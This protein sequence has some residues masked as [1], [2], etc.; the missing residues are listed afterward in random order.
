MTTQPDRVFVGAAW[1]YANGSLHAGHLA[2]AY[3]PAD[4][5]A[6][7]ARMTGAEVLFV[8]GSDCHGAPIT[9]R[10]DETGGSP[11]AV[12]SKYHQEFLHNWEQL[13]ISFDL[14]TTTMTSTHI[15]VVQDEFEKLR[16]RGLLVERETTA[17][18]DEQAERFLP[19]R[20]VIGECSHCGFDG[21]RGDQ[22]TSCGRPL[23]ADDILNARS[24]TTGTPVV[25]RPTRHFFLD[26]PQLEDQLQEWVNAS[27]G[28]WRRHVLGE[29]LG[30]LEEG[31]RPRAITRNLDWGVRVPVD[32]WD[33]RRIYVWF[34]AVTG[35]LSASMEWA[36]SQDDEDA[37]RHWWEDEDARQYYFLG[38]DNIPFH[39]L[40]WPAILIGRGDLAQLPY[41]VPANCFLNFAGEKASKSEGVGFS[42]N[43]LLARYDADAVRFYLATAM[44]ENDDS[45]FDLNDL[46]ARVNSELIG[47]WGNLVNRTVALVV[48]RLSGEVPSVDIDTE[49]LAACTAA[50]DDVSRHLWKAEFRKALRR[51]LE[52][53]QYGNAFI[54]RT[55]PW[56]PSMSP[57][58]V[59][60]ALGNALFI[61]NS[62]KVMMAPFVP[63]STEELHRRL[64]YSAALAYE[65]FVAAPVPAGRRLE[66]FPGLYKKLA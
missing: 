62:V 34:E 16:E 10:A 49:V 37:W 48:S 31:L 30:F 29:T 51:A 28:R 24:R 19:D 42:L 36:H 50:I 13:R 35:Y 53:A 23:D 5:F 61:V 41:D 11:G 58:D 6:R 26:L 18:Y 3:L 54:N 52:C 59:T 32:G 1:P 21:T 33:D 63:R 60:N 44:P 25:R 57:S 55:E 38:K 17:L 64:G 27:G 43:D 22:C 65:P 39:T 40:I 9:F 15:A 7:F 4:I 8:S 46:E 2:G 14:F 47:T 12:A 45:S 20:Y 66:R 56:S